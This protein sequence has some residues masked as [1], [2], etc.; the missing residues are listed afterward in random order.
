MKLPSRWVT[1]FGLVVAIAAIFVDPSVT[2]LVSTVLGEHA[3]TKLAAIGALIAA[4]GRA[5][6]P[7]AEPP[8]GQ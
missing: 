3:A 4:V 5:L 7:P 8:A 1:V 6:I 2:P